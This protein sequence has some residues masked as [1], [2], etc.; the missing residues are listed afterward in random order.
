[1][2]SSPY[3]F[4]QN[5]PKESR[6]LTNTEFG[7]Y[8]IIRRIGSGAMADVYLAEQRSLGRHVAIKILKQELNSDE[9]YVKRFLREAKAAARL[10]HPNIVHVYEVGERDSA[11]YIVQEYVQ[12]NNL[13]QY[14]Q[15]HGAMT[16]KQVFRVIWQVASALEAASQAGT[17]HRDIKPENIL[18]GEKLE[19]KVADFGLARVEDLSDPDLQLTKVGVT[20]GTPL[21]MSPEQSEGKPLDHRS[22]IYSL[23]I[24]SYHMLAGYPPFRGDTALSVAIQHLKKEADM[25]ETVRPDIPPALARIVHRMMAKSPNDRFQSVRQLKLELKQLHAKFFRNTEIS[26]TLAD[27]EALPLDV[28]DSSLNTLTDKLQTTMIFET[29]LLKKRRRFYSVALACLLIFIVGAVFGRQDNSERILRLD[30]DK[31]MI[32]KQGN[33]YE[34]WIL[35]SRLQTPQA[36][37]SVIEDW[38]NKNMAL[39]AKQQLAW[40]YYWNRMPEQ[41]G[42]Y[43][44]ELAE[45]SPTSN[46]DLVPFGRAGLAWVYKMQGRTEESN[47]LIRQL[48]TDY[49]PLPGSFSNMTDSILRSLRQ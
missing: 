41:A 21:Y 18:L 4:L 49:N 24:T 6:D 9:T 17:V 45:L 3:D 26:E 28:V 12:G 31:K 35:A 23:G 37:Q 14:L 5:P 30:E 22:D 36:W 13:A 46:P 19:V 42:P 43:F 32:P 8:H 15:H 44:S 25:L 34:Q 27:W 2:S 38:N 11:R 33:V 16:S 1:M 39:M 48:T 20:L 29:K 47:Q 7:D 10:V 40:Y